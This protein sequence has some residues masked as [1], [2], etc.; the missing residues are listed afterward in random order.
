VADVEALEALL[1]RLGQAPA[2]TVDTETTSTD[3]MQARLVG[4][5]LTDAE[6]RGYYIPVRAPAGDPQLP[7][8]EALSALQPLLRDA[9]VPKYAHNAKYD[10]TV[11]ERAGAPVAGLTFDTMIAEWLVNP[12]SKY[13]GLKSLAWARLQENMTPITELIGSGR[14]QR[15]MDQVAVRRAAPYA[16]ADVDMTHRL[17]KILTQELKEKEQWALFTE[18]EMPLIPV[19][20]DMEMHGVLLDVDFLARMSGEL[21]ERLHQ[22]EANIHEMVGYTFN[23]N[24][25]QQLSDAL[26][27]ALGLPTQGLR[28][29]K[30]GHFST[31]ADVLERLQDQHPIIERILEYRELAK[32]KSTY[33]DSLPQLVNPR[34]GRLHTSYNQTGTVTGRISSSDPNLQNIPIRTPLGRQVRRAIVAPAGSRLISADYS[35][36]ELRVMAH[37][38]GDEGLLNAFARGEDI[39]ASTAAAILN[40]PL[41]EVTS[42]MRRLAKAVN[43]GLSYGQTAYGLAR[44]TGLTQPEAEEFIKTY[45]ERFPKVREYIEQTKVLATRQG[46]VETLLGRRRYFP[47]LQPGSKASY[48]ARQAAERMA[49]NAPIQGTAADIIKLAMIRLHRALREW[50]L[51]SRMI[52]QVHD[53]IVVE[54]PEGEID[55]VTS[56]M[57][58]TMEDAFELRA[59][60][61]IDLKVGPNWEEMDPR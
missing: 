16:C 14:D 41:A 11:L 25:T 44:A 47:E 2:I 9:R 5:A 23:V 36:V 53:D 51:E 45:F 17:V 46:Y 20:A 61:K 13:L 42:D 57:R 27:E 8:Q 26:F 38:S 3:A 12:A 21:A 54:A 10:L 28:R 30:T 60:L 15:T 39:H 18:V 19:L 59:P 1:A 4:V 58:E 37:I 6:E 29:T 35:Q 7:P 48:N 32:L 24:S 40:V 43:F 52:L 22:L 34:T 55:P 33:L 56:L 50:G 31:A 49:I